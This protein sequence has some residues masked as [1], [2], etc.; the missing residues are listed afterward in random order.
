M[1]SNSAR[2]AAARS[3]RP[4]TRLHEHCLELAEDRGTDDQRVIATEYV[5]SRRRRGRPPKWRADTSTLVSRTTRTQRVG[6]RR[7]RLAARFHGSYDGVFGQGAGSRSFFSIRKELIPS[8]ASLRV[9]AERFAQE[10]A[11]CPALL[12]RQA[13]DLDRELWR[14]GDRHCAGRAHEPYDNTKSYPPTA[15]RLAKTGAIAADTP[16]PS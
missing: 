12:V 1:A 5:G 4:A 16:Q 6:L 3:P 8:S 2:T 15:C 9:L 13:V 11:A 10:F 14:Q 7:E